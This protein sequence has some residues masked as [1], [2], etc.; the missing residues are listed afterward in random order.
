VEEVIT[1]LA[2]NFEA[3]ESEAFSRDNGFLTFAANDD[4]P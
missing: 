3:D 1:L 4:C 2:G